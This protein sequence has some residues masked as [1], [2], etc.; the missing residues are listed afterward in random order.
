M[1]SQTYESHT[2]TSSQSLT[3]QH[4]PLVGSK[5]LELLN[6]IWAFIYHV[7]NLKKTFNTVANSCMQSMFKK[8][9][10]SQ[11]HSTFPIVITKDLTTIV[12]MLAMKVL[13]KLQIG[14]VKRASTHHR[15]LIILVFVFIFFFVKSKLPPINVVINNFHPVV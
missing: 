13:K 8:Q 12:F 11:Y 14:N 9:G 4:F 1:F 6:L 2:S 7:C 10:S 3:A 5:Y 15:R